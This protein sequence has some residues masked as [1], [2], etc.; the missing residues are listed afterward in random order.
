MRMARASLVGALLLLL[1][2]CWPVPGQGPDRNADN[3]FEQTITAANVSGLKVV[4]NTDTGGQ[5][6]S[7]PVVSDA[8]VH[9]T[10]VLNSGGYVVELLT[11]H[12]DTGGHMWTAAVS[13]CCAPGVPVFS[14]P[15]V[16]SARVA[17]GWAFVKTGP[18]FISVGGAPAF[19]P[20]TGTPNGSVGIGPVEAVRGSTVVTSFDAP[21]PQFTQTRSFTAT[22]LADQSKNFGGTLA[23]PD[24]SY[25]GFTLGA[26]HL[27]YVGL[28][29]SSTQPGQGSNVFGVRAYPATQA[30]TNC[31]A[32]GDLACPQW[33]VPFSSLGGDPVLS[34]DNSTVYVVANPNGGGTLYALNAETGSVVWR[35]SLGTALGASP[36]L[37]NGKL[38]VPTDQGNVLV[39]DARGCAAAVCTPLWT[40]ATGTTGALFQPLVGGD[41]LYTAARESGPIPLPPAALRAFPLGGCGQATCAPIWSASAAGGLSDQP[42]VSNGRLFAPTGDGHLIAYGLG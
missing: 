6:V 19:D 9:V 38:F 23:Y 10:A 8:G 14:A 40:D 15:F 29:P 33:V 36:A 7:S 26:K 20:S 27:F 18:G 32:T 39:F 3:P 13:Q 4:W 37:A 11:Y 21:T 31:G 42:A 16:V 25:G 30:A 1:A 5:F 34:P 2:G 24:A 17:T 28:G 12:T 35:A 41:V 22:N